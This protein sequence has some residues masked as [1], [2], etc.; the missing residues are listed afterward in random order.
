VGPDFAV[1][2]DRTTLETLQAQHDLE[3][4]G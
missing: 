4:R 3:L 1:R 2:S